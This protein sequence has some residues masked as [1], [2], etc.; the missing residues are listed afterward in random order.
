MVRLQIK[1]AA[2][3]SDGQLQTKATA[4]TSGGQ[5]INWRYGSDIWWLGYKLQVQQW[6]LMVRLQT[7]SAAVTFDGQVTN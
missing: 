5:V 1:S 6:H 2:V 7:K 4:V 3:T